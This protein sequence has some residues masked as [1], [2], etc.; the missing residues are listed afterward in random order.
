MNNEIGGYNIWDSSFFFNSESI[1]HESPRNHYFAL[2]RHCIEA[3]IISLK[4][5]NIYL[6]WYT[7]QSVVDSVLKYIP[8]L[9]LHRYHIDNSLLPVLDWVNISADSLV[10][11]N[12]YF[13]LFLSPLQ[14]NKFSKN[15][16]CFICIDN[17]HSFGLG[18]QYPNVMCFSSPRK[19]LP[20]TDGGILYGAQKYLSPS[21]LNSLN[22]D[23]SL[24]RISWLFRPIQY[25]SRNLSYR[26]YLELRHQLQ[27]LPLS[28]MSII[29]RHLLSS[30]DVRL[31]IANRLTVF[32]SLRDTFCWPSFLP[33]PL[34][35]ENF[36]P[37]GFPLEVRSAPEAKKLLA[38]HH[39]YS[40]Q[41]W[42]HISEPTRTYVSTYFSEIEHTCSTN[43]LFLP[44]NSHFDPH[45]VNDIVVDLDIL[46]S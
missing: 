44:I 38:Q 8:T 27:S 40:I 21:M 33:Q 31:T 5:S 17:T 22:Q 3:L 12:N 6:P 19:F 20:V 13:G 28:K 43:L 26:D 18:T 24:D 25:G 11:V 32:N 41:Y 7:C 45:L 36:S 16:S 2:G 35:H 10:I 30:I 23:S 1:F 14:V 37:I 15:S 46:I 9:D 4:P 39:I 29:T 42:P 34:L